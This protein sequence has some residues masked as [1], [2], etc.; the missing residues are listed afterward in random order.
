MQ[1]LFHSTLP[2]G[3]HSTYFDVASVRIDDERLF[4]LKICLNISKHSASISLLKFISSVIPKE[5]PLLFFKLRQWFGQIIVHWNKSHVV[6]VQTQKALQF[7][8]CHSFTVSSFS[9]SAVSPSFRTKCAKNFT[10]SLNRLYDFNISWNLARLT[11]MSTFSKLAT[12][13]VNVRPTTA[14]QYKEPRHVPHGIP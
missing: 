5:S 13:S 3:Q 12:C 6:S 7:S 1:S 8:L 4:W 14:T 2:L 9:A 10:S 11:L